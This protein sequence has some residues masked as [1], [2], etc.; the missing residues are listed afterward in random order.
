MKIF[1]NPFRYVS[2]DSRYVAVG[3]LLKRRLVLMTGDVPFRPHFA[4]RSNPFLDQS[5][6][7]F[8]TE[9]HPTF[10]DGVYIASMKQFHKEYV[11]EKV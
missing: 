5:T 6:R 9:K 3:K 10:L 8:N 4:D 11:D 7:H 2:W 1:K